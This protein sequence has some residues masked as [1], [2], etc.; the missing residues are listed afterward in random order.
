M[1]GKPPPSDISEIIPRNCKHHIYVF[2]T[3]E[4]MRSIQTSLIYSSKKT[5]ELKIQEHLGKDYCVISAGTIGGTHL[6]AFCHVGIYHLISKIQMKTVSTG[7]GNIIGNKGAVAISFYLGG[8]SLLFIGCHLASGQNAVSRRNND[9]R[10][11]EKEIFKEL[12]N[13][14]SSLVDYCFILGDLNYRINGSRDDVELL[15]NFNIYEVLQ[16]GDQ[17]KIELSENTA[18]LKFLEGKIEFP[19]TYRFNCGTNSFDSSKKR[20]VPAWTDRIIYKAKSSDDLSQKTY[21]CISSC[22]TSDHKPVYSQFSLKFNPLTQNIVVEK[23][24]KTCQVF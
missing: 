11:I 17:L 22:V 8:T 10:R 18:F 15:V 9:F 14:A 2:S 23:R 4:C 7:I 3:Q 6:I 16:K 1:Y 21:G 5:W 24:S 19:P 13:Q 12:T 20:R